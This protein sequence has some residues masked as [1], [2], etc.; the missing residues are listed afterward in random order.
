V[1]IDLWDTDLDERGFVLLA[2]MILRATR[3]AALSDEDLY[4]L[5]VR[6][7]NGRPPLVAWPPEAPAI[8]R[9]CA[10]ALAAQATCE[11]DGATYA[12]TDRSVKAAGE[13]V[14][15]ELRLTSSE[16]LSALADHWAEVADSEM[17]NGG[18]SLLAFARHVLLDPVAGLLL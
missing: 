18:S 15:A 5:L 9:R 17:P 4:P 6:L 2:E 10:V 14:V 16:L 8:A 13:A 3:E 1:P 11:L 12:P 7:W